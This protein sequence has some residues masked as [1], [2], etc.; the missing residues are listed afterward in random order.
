MKIRNCVA[1]VTGANRG[2]GRAIAVELVERGARKVYGTSRSGQ[3]DF[4]SGVT[5]LKLDVTKP[6]DVAAAA[7]IATDVDLLVNNAGIADFVG[8]L[9]TQSIDKSHAI[10]ETNFYGPVRTSQAFAPI[11]A[12][13]GGGAIV[14]VLSI[15]SWI[16]SPT[17]AVYAASKSAA[18]AFT[19][20]LRQHLRTQG[21]Q[22]VGLHVGFIDTDMTRGVDLPKLAP[23]DVARVTLDGVEAGLEEVLADERTRQVKQ[24]L[25]A[26]RPAYL[27][28]AEG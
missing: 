5:P 7:A 24:S 11:L 14:N 4:P 18:W 21:T 1:L 12:R 25:S 17:L 19:N 8:F 26:A 13:N 6:E 22:V 9:D 2:L 27:A 28:M 23:S 3:G 20:A 15:A 16:T 10:F